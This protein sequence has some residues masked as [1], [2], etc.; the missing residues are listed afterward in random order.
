[1]PAYLYGKQFFGGLGP[2]AK[3]KVQE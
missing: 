1:M 2:N 3:G